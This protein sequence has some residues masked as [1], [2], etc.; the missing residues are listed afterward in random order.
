MIQHLPAGHGK[1]V[2]EELDS[3]T[4]ISNRIWVNLRLRRLVPKLWVSLRKKTGQVKH[5]VLI[6]IFEGQIYLNTVSASCLELE[7]TRHLD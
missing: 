1:R 4:A 7:R 2:A 5:G 6:N 3:R